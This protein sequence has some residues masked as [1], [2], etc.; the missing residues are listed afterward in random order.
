MESILLANDDESSDDDAINGGSNQVQNIA[1]S[2]S[3]AP[4]QES[5]YSARLKSLYSSTQ[6]TQNAGSAQ[7]QQQQP[8]PILQQHQQQTPRHASHSNLTNSQMI[9]PSSSTSRQIS[10][11]QQQQQPPRSTLPNRTLDPFEPTPLTTMIS[12]HPSVPAQP[13]SSSLPNNMPQ[14]R[15]QSDSESLRPSTGHQSSSVHAQPSHHPSSTHHGVS[16]THHSHAAARAKAERDAKK[17]KEHFLMFTKVLMK[18]LEQKDP[19]MHARA[20]EVIRECAEKNKK[21]EQGYESVTASMKTRLRTTVGEQYWKRADSYL[22]HFQEIQRQKKLKQYQEQQK[23]QQELKKQQ[24]QQLLLKKQEQQQ[25]QQT[26]LK[27]QQQEAIRRKQEQALL[28]KKKEEERKIKEERQADILSKQRAKS[29]SD[30]LPKRSTSVRDIAKDAKPTETDPPLEYNEFM[31][32]IDQSI[33]YDW[34]KAGLLLGDAAD[35][36]LD[37]EQQNLLYGKS[38]PKICTDLRF[39]KGWSDRN[40]LSTRNSWAMVRLPELARN[41]KAS[42]SVGPLLDG[43]ALPNHKKVIVESSWHN[44][45]EAEKDMLLAILS[46][47]TQLYMKQILDKALQCARQRENLEVTRLWYLQESGSNPPLGLRLGCDIARHY[48]LSDGQAALTVK[49]MEESLKRNSKGNCNRQDQTLLSEAI[50]MGDLACRPRLSNAVEAADHHAKRSFEISCGKDAELPF[51]RVPKQ[52]KILAQ[53]FHIGAEL[54]SHRPV[55]TL[56]F[57]FAK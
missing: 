42:Q 27:K 23:Q 57:H 53:D 15:T 28:K 55:H 49:R 21:K 41:N 19:Q 35:I 54:S 52:A 4:P 44:E 40:L 50:S 2:T 3:Q 20:K 13:Q 32:L 18:Y 29:K 47:A 26:E 14:H 11:T 51:G 38:R 37:A 56:T 45:E 6:T 7:Q 39:R 10:S 8:H 43:I 5:N 31:E 48:A 25:K 36:D 24:Q 33:N 16:T 22:T 30:P 12:R 9:Q 1:F 34:T 17:A 46:E